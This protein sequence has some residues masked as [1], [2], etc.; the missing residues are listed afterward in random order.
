M[1]KRAIAPVAID[2][3][4]GVNEPLA[5]T[6]GLTSTVAPRPPLGAGQA[7]TLSFTVTNGGQAPATGVVVEAPLPAQLEYQPGSTRR[8]RTVAVPDVVAAADEGPPARRGRVSPPPPVPPPVPPLQ[9][10]Y[11]LGAVSPGAS[12]TVT[13]A[14][15][16]RVPVAS[17][18]DL[19]AA[20]V[21][22]AESP[23]PA[24]ANGP[25]AVDLAAFADAI[26]ALPAVRVAQPFGLVDL[27]PGSVAAGGKP[28][29]A[30][31]KVVGLDPRYAQDIPL[32]GFS[33]GEFTR[34]TAF[35]SAA[36]AER[37]GAG[38]GATL[39][40][41]I[42]GTPESTA[43]SVPVGAVADLSG[44]D[45]LFASR[46]EDNLGDFVSAPF[47]V[48]VDLGAFARRVLPAVRADAAA[49]VP[50]VTQ[51]PALE[52]HVQLERSR[53]NADPA[54][55]RRTTTGVRRSI[56]RLYPG[57]VTAIDNVSAGL[58]R[59]RIDASLAKVLFMALGLPGALLAGYLAFFG[60]TLL[61][62]AERRER[63]LLR[64][65]GFTP[66]TL[67][68]AVAY[69]A[70]AI[71]VVGS[72]A[73]AALALVA[74][75]ALFPPEVEPGSPA[76]AFA[77]GAVVAAVVTLL[78]IYLPARKALLRDVTEA[79][80]EV[81]AAERPGWLRA[82]LDLW[83]LVGAAVVSAAFVL[84]GGFRPKPG[85]V[86]ETVAKS[87]YIL[88]APW[89][90]WLGGVLLAARILLGVSRRK[91]ARTG[92][93]DG[94]PD[95]RQHLV[96]RVMA[97]S[98]ARRPAVVTAGMIMVGLAVAFGVSLAIFVTTFRAQQAADA[99]FVVGS[100]VRVTLSPGQPL[101]VD[102]EQR[103][104]VPGVQALTPVAQVPDAVLGSEK[105]LFAAVDPATYAGVADLS[106]D[107]FTAGSPSEAMAKMAQDPTAIIIDQETAD[108]FN[109]GLDDTL[110][111]QVPSPVLGQPVLLPLTVVAKVVQ[112]PGYPTG[113][114]FVGNLG[115]YQQATGAATPSY[116]LLRTGGDPAT[117]AR[118]EVDL[119]QS[120]GSEVPARI[121]T[122]GAIGSPDQSSIA[123][124]SLTG[125]GR[126]EGFYMLLIASLGIVIFVAM[127]LTQRNTERAVMRALGLA[128]RPLLAISLAEAALVATAGV[129]VGT[130][131]GVPM[132]Q[133]FVQILRRI[134]I[135][136]PVLSVTPSLAALLLGLL[137]VTVA[138]AAAILAVS[139]RRLKLVELLR[140]E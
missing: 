41:H 94:G 65:R 92:S 127:L 102:L 84:T 32:L 122:A 128:R 113:L 35:A 79:R 121:T 87:F 90:L 19:V 29:D 37:L 103:L 111:L 124:L 105:L 1:T 132:A 120:L 66:L 62:E 11:E 74:A 50:L 40:V 109:V 93:P 85:A 48:G 131:V 83:L 15:T 44:A 51:P 49:P 107:F 8:D 138:I 4:A 64:A 69:Q 98:V 95:F 55:A 36:V 46:A 108:T 2:M 112:F 114:D 100:D 54:A 67:T 57:E 38:P 23:V 97:R 126:V 31:V 116:Y 115:A 30:G 104:R 34:G 26:R 89:C 101:P 91:G 43:F 129:V 58:D 5:S 17:A 110:K 21:R 10:G 76:L 3:Q 6:L 39:D 33:A 73:G 47:V 42:P 27:P 136:P 72:V 88:L 78:A 56:E 106:P 59:A 14:A 53:L 22:S 18:A 130:V 77:V 61:A 133:L 82:R 52:V 139:A 135:V 125:L 119:Q 81:V 24:A 99:R 117:T 75:N 28:L 118:V 45:A 71:A 96:G 70:A 140:T 60:G 80:Q 9:D 13:Y 16:T 7:V 86:E 12:T 123:G 20:T 63:A 134:F 137:L 25:K 68:R